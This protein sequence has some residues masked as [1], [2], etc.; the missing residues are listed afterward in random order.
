[1][2][3]RNKKQDKWNRNKS[4]HKNGKINLKAHESAMKSKEENTSQ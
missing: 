3:K 1:M 2:R 4:E